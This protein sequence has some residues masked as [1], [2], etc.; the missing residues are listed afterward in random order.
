MMGAATLLP[1]ASTERAA[2]IKFSRE[3]VFRETPLLNESVCVLDMCRPVCEKAD[4]SGVSACCQ[5]TRE[6]I[7][8]FG[9]HGAVNR[10][11][12][13]IFRKGVLFQ[14]MLGCADVRSL[15]FRLNTFPLRKVTEKIR[16]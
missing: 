3:Q 16:Q 9:V 1:G 15:P 14:E 12:Y 4:A 2:F 5:N 10:E 8:S 11:N 13:Q 7:W 6:K